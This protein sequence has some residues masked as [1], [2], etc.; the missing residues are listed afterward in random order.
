M[1]SKREQRRSG[2]DEDVLGD[3]LSRSWQIPAV[4]FS[5]FFVHQRSGL[6]HVILGVVCRYGHIFPSPELM[7]GSK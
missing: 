6:K 7:M 2:W 3:V 4:F 5:P 1:A